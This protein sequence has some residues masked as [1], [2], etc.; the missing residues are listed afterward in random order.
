MLLFPLR[1][2]MMRKT[3]CTISISPGFSSSSSTVFSSV[4]MRSTASSINFCLKLS[5]ELSITVAL[6]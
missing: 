6:Y 2:C 1:V 3:R 4:S 5:I